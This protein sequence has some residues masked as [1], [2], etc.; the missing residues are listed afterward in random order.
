[1]R[2]AVHFT[3]KEGSQ[4][5]FCAGTEIVEIRQMLLPLSVEPVNKTNA[6]ITEIRTCD[7]AVAAGCVLF[8]QF[9]A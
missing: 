6:A 4:I 1:M 9:M 7:A 2:S 8:N 3:A 5:R